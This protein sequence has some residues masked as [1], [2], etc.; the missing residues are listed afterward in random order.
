MVTNFTTS[1]THYRSR[2]VSKPWPDQAPGR[3]RT[4]RQVTWALLPVQQR[5][6][7]G[8]AAGAPQQFAQR[9]TTPPPPP[10]GFHTEVT[11]VFD[12]YHLV[13]LRGEDNYFLT[14]LS[15]QW[16]TFHPLGV[17]Y[18]VFPHQWSMRE[19]ILTSYHYAAY[20][21]DS[22]AQTVVSHSAS[23]CSMKNYINRKW[24]DSHSGRQ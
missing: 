11:E 14:P 19:C 22:D 21:N 7:A 18:L 9:L 2:C 5:V 13:S 3:T 20:N 23:V 12:Y 10:Q 24:D 16:V 6:S 1:R 8:G 15:G 4:D 17:I